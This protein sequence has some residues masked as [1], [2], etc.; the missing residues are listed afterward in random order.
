MCSW[1]DHHLVDQILELDHGADD[2]E[3]VTIILTHQFKSQLIRA[4]F[5]IV[6]FQFYYQSDAA[7]GEDDE[8]SDSSIC[9]GWPIHTCMAK[10]PPSIAAILLD[11]DMQF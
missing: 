9:R 10:C 7:W 3:V 11:F 1:L 2:V 4:H 6:L 8:I 5:T